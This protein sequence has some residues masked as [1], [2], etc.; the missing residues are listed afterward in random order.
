M[1]KTENPR[2]LIISGFSSQPLATKIAEDLNTIV[3]DVIRKQFNDKEIQTTINS[4]IRGREVVVI[5]SAAGDPNKQEKETRLLMRAANRAGAAKVTLL[6]PYMWYG[7]S[8][9]NWDERNAPAL[10]D[11]IETLR[12]HCDDVIVIDPH[13]HSFVREKFLDSNNNRARNCTN[14]HFSYLYASQ[15]KFLF[16]QNALDPKN[17][18][19]AHADAGSTKRI[20]RSFREALYSTL[21]ISENPDEDSWPQGLKSRNKTS[22]QIK[23][24]GFSAPVKG[25]DVVIFEDMIGSGG[26]ACDLA[27]LLKEKGARTV[28]LFATTGLFTTNQEKSEKITDAVKRINTSDINAVYITDTFDHQLIDPKIHKAIE[29][30]PIIHVL[31]TASFLS[32]IIEAKHTEVVVT[33]PNNENSVSALLRGNHPSIIS[34]PEEIFTPVPAKKNSSFRNSNS[35]PPRLCH[36]D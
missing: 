10:T 27:K 3:V 30:S 29:N 5:A 28:T 25:K 18:I 14:V 8:D 1:M 2:P 23:V 34:N 7:R 32:Q 21:D 31:K 11:T 35:K 22:G 9:D 13:N 26:T 4:N 6:I 24:S 12:D 36:I 15:L 33:T 16:N 17:L 20:G 19:L